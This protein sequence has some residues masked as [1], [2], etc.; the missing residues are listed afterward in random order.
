MVINKVAIRKDFAELGDEAL[1]ARR[2]GI[3]RKMKVEVMAA[4]S[5]E[6]TPS[7]QEA[8]G[9]VRPIVMPTLAVLLVRVVLQIEEVVHRF[10]LA[11]IHLA[12]EDKHP[13]RLSCELPPNQF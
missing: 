5:R 8:G 9:L 2:K 13:R 3:R 6:R 4:W 7:L 12:G 1:T 11:F 10:F